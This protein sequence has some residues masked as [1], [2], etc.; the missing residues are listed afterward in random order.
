MEAGER[1][2]ISVRT[3]THKKMHRKH[4]DELYQSIN[5]L[6]KRK[7]SRVNVM[8]NFMCH[9]FMLYP[10]VWS[11]ITLDVSVKVFFVLFCFIRLRF[12]SVY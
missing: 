12:E 10:D 4:L 7:G 5:A 3:H 6:C 9:N 2:V 11:N 1:K 8:V